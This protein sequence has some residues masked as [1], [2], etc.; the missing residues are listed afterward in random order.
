[1]GHQA[2]IYGRIQEHW[3]GTSARWPI[4]PE[5]NRC[6]LE[7]L[8]DRDDHWP[9]LTRHMFAVAARPF[10][11]DMDRGD[12]RGSVIHFAASTK[13]DPEESKWP[14]WF[15]IKLEQLVLKRLLW[16]SAKVHF[17]SAFFPDR[18]VLY[19]VDRES[20][21]ALHAELG[22]NR[23]GERVENEVRWGRREMKT[24]TERASWLC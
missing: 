20:L 9:F 1:M 23:F 14:E 7:A 15:L 2:I 21:A 18:A 17:E 10:H 16:S 5:Y 19:E 12:Y 3:E 11:G 22:R 4:T 6:V 13:D 24:I 8:P